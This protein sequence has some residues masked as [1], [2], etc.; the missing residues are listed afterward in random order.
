MP[1]GMAR[2]WVGGREARW[3][4]EGGWVHAGWVGRTGGLT[5][6]A[7]YMHRIS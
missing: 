1:V 3:E 4:C 6:Q 2:G 5:D 7:V